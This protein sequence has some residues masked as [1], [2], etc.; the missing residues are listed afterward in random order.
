[1]IFLSLML[2]Y[3]VFEEVSPFR[4][5]FIKYF[6]LFRCQVVWIISE[7]IENILFIKTKQ[8][9]TDFIRIINP[10]N[11]IGW[12]ILIKFTFHDTPQLS[13]TYYNYFLLFL[14]THI[15]KKVTALQPSPCKLYFFI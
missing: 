4:I 8:P 12:V 13:V 6:L 11:L 7:H 15:F 10:P 2:L 1:M 14:Q 3:S 5:F 9:F